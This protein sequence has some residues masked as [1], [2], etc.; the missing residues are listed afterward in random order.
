MGKITYH[1]FTWDEKSISNFWDFAA[2]WEPWSK[3]YFSRQVGKGIVNF[4]K[5]IG[6]LNG[7]ILDYGCG[8]GDL[9][10]ELLKVG[11]FCYG[12]DSSR[13]SVQSINQRFNGIKQW[14]GAKVLNGPHIPY[15]NDEF[16]LVICIETI[17]HVLPE[18][19]PQLLAEFKRIL[20]PKT[21]ALFITMPN[22]EDLSYAQIY[23]PSCNSLFHRYQHI[24][25]YTKA[26][27]EEMLFKN[28]FATQL[29]SETHF[30]RFQQPYILNLFDWSPRY[31]RTLII[32][33]F[34][35][36]KDIFQKK[37]I[38]NNKM[39]LLIGKGEHL[40]WLGGKMEKKCA[41]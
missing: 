17:E 14:F 24:S 15:N 21:G 37:K 27:I 34:A 20:K 25:K 41:E 33:I 4:L 5:K 1:P 29:C 7:K 31:L 13:E 36:V 19:I 16:D 2:N 30:V 10:G 32:R 6:K 11:T 18:R 22:N 8:L 12:A 3:D 26:S 9:T 28:G 38:L 39:S 40:F 35:I 23:C